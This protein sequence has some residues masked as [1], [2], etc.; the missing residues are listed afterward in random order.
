MLTYLR[1]GVLA[2][3]ALVLLTLALANRAVVT[4]QLL[5]DVLAGLLGFNLSMTL[6]LFMILGL[7]VGFGL[8]LG[9][10]WEWVRE[11]G[12]RREASQAR[13]EA[14]AL[15]ADLRRVETIAPQTRKDDVLAVLDAR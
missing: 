11:Y 15:R 6:P 3:I 10:V 1:Y 14:D 12:Y 5:P 13:R 7:A 8:L 2:I 4:V 9:F